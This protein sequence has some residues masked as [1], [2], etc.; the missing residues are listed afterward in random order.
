MDFIHTLGFSHHL[1]RP[2]KTWLYLGCCSCYCLRTCNVLYHRKVQHTATC[3]RN[4]WSFWGTGAAQHFH[5]FCWCHLLL[6]GICSGWKHF[7]FL[8]FV[9]FYPYSVWSTFG[10]FHVSPL[11][12]FL[13]VCFSWR[14]W[15]RGRAFLAVFSLP[16]YSIV[17]ALPLS[18]CWHLLQNN[19]WQWKSMLV[20]LLHQSLK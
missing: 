19:S 9:F 2:P 17:W 13:K 3:F 10:G 15:T 20:S 1:S 16:F 8:L 18:F 4:T 11:N 7:K 14:K 6:G 12:I 5:D